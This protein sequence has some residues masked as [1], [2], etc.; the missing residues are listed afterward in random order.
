MKRKLILY[1][2]LIVFLTSGCQL[3]RLPGKLKVYDNTNAMIEAAKAIVSEISIEDFNQLLEEEKPLV[4]DIRS[5]EERDSGYI[6]GS[7]FIN[8]GVLEFRI[9]DEKVWDD[10]G[11]YIP[12]KSELI[13][14]YCGS[15][16]RSA[17]ATKTLMQLGYK[18]VKSLQGGWA[19]WNDAY[20]D[21]I[22]K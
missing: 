2:L 9:D 8:R 13:I 14:I 3:T 17:L 21:I 4:I 6:P 18:N 7:I 5:N 1:C 15:G 22:E 19:D 10:F 16:S 12:S 11:R 20:P